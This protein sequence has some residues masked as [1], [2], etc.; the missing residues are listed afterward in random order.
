MGQ[1]PPLRQVP[2][3]EVV[4]SKV[5]VL[6]GTDVQDAFISLEVRKGA[7]NEPFAI[8]ACLGWSILGGSVSCSDKHQFN[9]SHVSCKKISLS[10]QLQDFW[11]VESYGTVKQSLKSVS[12]EDRKAMK[13]IENTN[14]KVD[15]HYQIGLLWKQEDPH[16]PFNRAEAEARLHH[17]K[18]QFS[19]DPGLEA[20]YRAVI[21]F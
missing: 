18:R 4:T 8:R 10:R 6:I 19:R 15:D 14:S 13:I 17:L 20:K 2:F 7:S 9:F 5:S 3:P 1:W 12:V 16:K 21:F 11:R